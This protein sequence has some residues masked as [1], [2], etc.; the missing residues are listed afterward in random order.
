MTILS[1]RKSTL[2][3]GIALA[4]IAAP[5]AFAQN[6]R[7]A[8]GGAAA[9]AATGAVGGAIVGGPIGAAAGAVIGGVAGA[10]VGSIT[11]E[12]R[13]YARQYVTREKRQTVR[14]DG[15]VAVGSELP[16]NVTYYRV[17]GNPRLESYRYAY[18]NDTYVLVDAS[19]R[20]VEIIE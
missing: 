16:S 14:I 10:T 1:L 11:P 8:A 18:V 20:V 17:Q 5:A 6:E 2:A 15:R 3:L 7:G 13:V 9:G 19:G 12:D 4:V